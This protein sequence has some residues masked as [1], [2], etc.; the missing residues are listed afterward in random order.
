MNKS[1]QSL[2]NNMVQDILNYLECPGKAPTLRYLNR[3]V[4]AYIRKVP[5][6]SVS[7]I[8][9]RHTTPITEDCPRWPEEFWHDAIQFCFG[10]TC[11]ESNLA[12]YSLLMTLGYDGYLTVNDMG[13]SRGCHAATVIILDGEKYLVDITI[14]VHNAVRL[15]R[16]KVTRQ[17][18]TFH[19][20]TIRP[21]QEN[22]YEVERSHHS[23]RNAFTLIDVPVSLPDYLT[24]V[25]N[26]YKET[27]FF[28]KSVVMVKV[29]EDK[30]WRFF[31]D[32]QPYKLE[33]FNRS[34]KTEILLAQET[35]TES[36]AS[37]FQMPIDKISYA[38]SRIQ[39]SEP[40]YKAVPDN[41]E[42]RSGLHA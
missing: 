28:L 10:G 5:W 1:N 21:V 16:Q 38:I 3:L 26:D 8:V 34:G 41:L 11:F 37:L 19:N 14:P 9:K 20:Y 4:Y 23:H 31:S 27:G 18:T 2:D 29:I 42:E 32:I 33:S 40:A 25:E 17:R 22:K 7:R 39:L 13:D 15:D 30:T 6:E 12:F 35:M 24:I 36:L